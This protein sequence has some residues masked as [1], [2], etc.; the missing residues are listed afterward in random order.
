[1]GSS[2]VAN[3]GT[4]VPIT[5]DVLVEGSNFLNISVLGYVAYEAGQITDDYGAS[6]TVPSTGVYFTD[7]G[8]T[9]ISKLSYGSTA[10]HPLDEKFIPDTVA[11]KAD[12]L[13]MPP[14]A[15]AGQFIVVTSV[16]ENGKV[17]ATKAVTLESVQPSNYYNGLYGV[18]GTSSVGTIEE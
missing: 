3:N 6:W 13:P 2:V 1:V 7:A 11:R 18:Y 16:D 10:V 12:T 9:Y 8:G 17:T 4:E 15:S 14:T 5:E